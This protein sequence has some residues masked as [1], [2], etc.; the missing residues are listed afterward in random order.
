MP[1]KIKCALTPY[2]LLAEKE[3]QKIL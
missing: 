3:K 2:T 1:W